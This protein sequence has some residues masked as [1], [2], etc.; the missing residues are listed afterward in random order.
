MET[1]LR[2]SGDRLVDFVFVTWREGSSRSSRRYRF[3]WTRIISR[4][5]V[6]SIYSLAPFSP[7]PSRASTFSFSLSLSLSLSLETFARYSRRVLIS[8]PLTS[9]RLNGSW[10]WI[11]RPANRNSCYTDSGCERGDGVACILAEKRDSTVERGW[12]RVFEGWNFVNREII[13]V[14][15]WDLAD[16]SL[17]PFFSIRESFFSIQNCNIFDI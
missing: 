9:T 16:F 12:K 15:I 5:I 7:R 14:I 4:G 17:S 13:F 6:Y 3:H 8:P 10:P 1:T 11:V 2:P